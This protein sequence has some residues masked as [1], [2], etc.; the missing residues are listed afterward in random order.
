MT[1]QDVNQALLQT[2]FLYGANSAYIEALAGEI[3]AGPAFGRAGLARFLRR[4][5]RR[6]GER[7][8][9]R[10]RRVVAQ[11]Q[12]AGDAEGRSDQRA[13]R[14]LAGDGKGG[15]R[16]AARQGG[17]SCA[18]A[19]PTRGRD[20]PRDARFGARADDDPRLPHAR[21]SATP[22]SIRSASSRRGITRSCIPRPTA[23]RK[24]TTTARSSSITC[25][26]SNTRPCARCWRSCAAPIAARSASNSSISP[27]RP[28]R[29]GFRSAS[30]VPTRKSSSPRRASAPS[31]RKLVEAEGFENFF[32]VKYPGAKRFGL[33][34]ARGDDPGAR[35]DHQARRPARPARDRARHGPPRPA[36][37]AEPGDGQAAPRHLP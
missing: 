14:R 8:Q 24:P 28:R 19:A 4:A 16:Q 32:D 13:R 37:R 2:S 29:P 27:I 25:S 20:P 31:C 6:S 30:K 12:L 23:S 21:P 26:G 36:Q 34:G 7:R 9:D 10:E 22:I 11:A 3:R 15:R 5:R 17:G 33:D 1:R 18:E 35:A